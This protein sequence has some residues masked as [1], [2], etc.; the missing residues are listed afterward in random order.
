MISWDHTTV[1][2]IVFLALAAAIVVRFPRTGGPAMLHA[3]SAPSATGDEAGSVCPMH[4]EVRQS[5][6]GTCPLCGMR[7]VAPSHEP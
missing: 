2:N 1:V 7:S 3:M 4:P 6:P 5:E